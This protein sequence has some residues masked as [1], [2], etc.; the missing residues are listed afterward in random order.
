MPYA[1]ISVQPLDAQALEELAEDER[2]GATVVFRG[3]VRNHDGGQLVAGIQYSAHPFAEDALADIAE[4]VAKRDQ[5]HQ[6]V[7]AHRV[8]DLEVGDDAFIAIVSAEHRAEAFSACLDIVEEIKTRVP[9]W[10]LQ[11]F[12][13]GSTSW[14]GLP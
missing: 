5:V 4:G 6:V 3:V 1:F 11:Q 10:K 14:S 13:N 8:G 2:C 12:S 7:V 9:I